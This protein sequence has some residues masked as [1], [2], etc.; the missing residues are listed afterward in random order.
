MKKQ[1]LLLLA[2]LLLIAGCSQGTELRRVAPEPAPE[3][4]RRSDSASELEALALA[5]HMS[6]S[7]DLAQEQ[8]RTMEL[9]PQNATEPLLLAHYS[10]WFSTPEISGYWSKHWTMNNC[11]PDLID[12]TGKREICSHYYPLIGP[13]DSSDPDL[14]EYH[15]LLMK[16]SGIDGIIIDFYGLQSFYDW[17]ELKEATDNV[18][19][20]FNAAGMKVAVMYLD[21]TVKTA[22]DNGFIS[23]PIAVAQADLDYIE[24]AY[25]SLENYVYINDEPLLM[26]Y[27]PSYFKLASEWQDLYTALSADAPLAS[28]GNVNSFS[29]TTFPWIEWP[30]WQ[31]YLPRYYAWV[32]WKGFNSAIGSSY[33]SYNDYFEEGG[34]GSSAYTLD[35]QDGQRF[36]NYLSYNAQFKPDIIQ[37]LSWNGF[38]EGTML[39]PTLEDGYKYLTE[40]QAFTNSSFTQAD[41]ELVTDIYLIRKE[42]G[43]HSLANQTATS[44]VADIHAGNSIDASF[45]KGLL[46]SV[47]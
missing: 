7:S 46:N 37:L 44:I 4:Q 36:S 34:W 40:L 32:N 30:H 23:D 26:N 8:L 21:R 2:F 35:D 3:L 33:H 39:E 20:A 31:D 5:P 24:E 12:Q 6:I 14:L 45:L 9:A 38:A 17:P 16:L 29:A 47:K 22:L 43:S 41:L 11:N 13:Y 25:F 15:I 19:A 27:G 18:M 10:P 1:T 42:L 28:L